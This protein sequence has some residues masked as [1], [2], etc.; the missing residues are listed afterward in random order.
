M[1]M[2]EKVAKAI[3]KQAGDDDRSDWDAHI[4]FARAAI[5]AMR[6]P[7]VTMLRAGLGHALHPGNT[8]KAMIDAALSEES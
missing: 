3:A 8:L 7:T 1:N 5:E 4:G 2:I 6:E